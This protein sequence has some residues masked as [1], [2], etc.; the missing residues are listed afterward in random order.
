MLRSFDQTE[1]EAD[2]RNVACEC[3]L[4]FVE[5]CFVYILFTK[6]ERLALTKDEGMWYNFIMMG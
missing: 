1:F 2:T 3:P 5:F 6:K 4:L